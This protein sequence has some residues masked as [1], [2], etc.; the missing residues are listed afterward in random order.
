MTGFDFAQKTGLP[1]QSKAL[2]GALLAG[3]GAATYKSPSF[4]KAEGS[5]HIEGPWSQ[6]GRLSVARHNDAILFSGWRKTIRTLDEIAGPRQLLRDPGS[7]S[8]GK[9]YRVRGR[10]HRIPDIK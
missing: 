5:L 10:F 1:R 3:R 7:N 2:Q 9:G 8:E 6:C 4:G